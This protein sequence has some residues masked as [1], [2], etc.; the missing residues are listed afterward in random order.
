MA[1]IKKTKFDKAFD[2][3]LYSVLGLL[4][5]SYLYILIYVVSASFSDPNAVYSGRVVLW[6]VDFTLQG[7]KRVFQEKMVLLGYR[8]SMLYMVTGTA[9]STALTL[10]GAYALSRRDL[11]G[12]GIVTGLLVFTMFFNGGIVPLYLIVRKLK[13]I[14]TMWSLVLP[15]AVSMSN[16]IIARTFYANSIP[17]GLLDAAKIDGSTNIGFFFRVALPLS[18]AIIAV[19]ALYYAV[20]LWNDYFN[21]M[22]YL[23]TREKYPLQ[24][25]LREILISSQQSA[26]MTGD[27][28][29][30]ELLAQLQ[31]I[32]KYTL[33][34]VGSLPLLMLYPFLQKYF[35]QGVLIGSLKE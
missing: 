2:I 30:Q 11:P 10:M 27:V 7:Y 3:I 12:R 8:N 24:L 25:F 28:L 19:I 22:I 26:A 32:I 6:P 31:E 29:E 15:G 1:A 9:I 5:A 23:K 14:D 16:V 17:T 33:I 35:V 21:A 4:A 18:K 13:M 34:V 20:G